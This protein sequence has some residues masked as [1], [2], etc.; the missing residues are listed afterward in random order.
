MNV[1]SVSTTVDWLTLIAEESYPIRILNDVADD[2]LKAARK[3]AVNPFACHVGPYE[4]IRFAGCTWAMK[5]DAVLLSLAGSLAQEQIKYVD[6]LED[7]RVT[8]L[9]IAVTVALEHRDR[10]GDRAYLA[11]C[12]KT[13]KRRYR[14]STS[15]IHGSD[16]GCTV[17][18][19]SRKGKN[20]FGRLYDKGIQSKDP[21]GEGLIW[22]YE[23]QLKGKQAQEAYDTFDLKGGASD[24]LQSAVWNW[25]L[26]RGVQPVF[27][28]TASMATFRRDTVAEPGNVDKKLAWLG[29][30]VAPVVR[31]L[32]LAGYSDAVYTM[33]GLDESQTNTL[34]EQ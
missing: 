7:V 2:I 22:R 18:L 33:L 31:D 5:G 14:A 8:R 19:G 26:D 24:D 21:A 28:P 27:E 17:Y 29:R 4:G 34:K 1:L 23:V 16:G 13:K 25:F 11:A 30:T 9:D 15:I 12:D 6:A 10:V 20:S 32:R 3:D